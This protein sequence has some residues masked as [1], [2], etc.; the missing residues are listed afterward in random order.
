MK[1]QQ[2]FLG[3]LLI[4]TW[5]LLTM[6]SQSVGASSYYMTPRSSLLNATCSST[7][8]SYKRPCEGDETFL[9][10]S[11]S[12]CVCDD[13]GYFD[14]R[15]GYCRIKAESACK[16]PR[17]NSPNVQPCVVGADCEFPLDIY[18]KPLTTSVDGTCKCRSGYRRIDQ[19]LC[20]NSSNIPN[21]FLPLKQSY[22]FIL[23]FLSS[24]YLSSF[25]Y[26]R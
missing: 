22:I 25:T 11:N 23:F 18:S 14:D 1:F 19:N 21:C 20:S 10:C 13:H 16:I 15:D 12:R 4:A 9:K 5:V 17:T 26:V 7:S 24:S 2:S 8:S 3:T 6:G